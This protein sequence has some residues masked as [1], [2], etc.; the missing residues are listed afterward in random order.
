MPL[1]VG[2]NMT[3]LSVQSISIVWFEGQHE[4]DTCKKNQHRFIRWPL[5]GG[6]RGCQRWGGRREITTPLCYEPVDYITQRNPGVPGA[7]CSG[8]AR[9]RAWKRSGRCRAFPATASTCDIWSECP[10]N[11]YT[12]T[13][14]LALWHAWRAQGCEDSCPS[15][16]SIM[17]DGDPLSHRVPPLRVKFNH[18]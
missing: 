12:P 3:C 11:H 9:R 17:F 13:L 7:E 16:Y 10:R 5:T 2:P 15:H 14:R 6:R 1:P 8:G 4:I 18:F